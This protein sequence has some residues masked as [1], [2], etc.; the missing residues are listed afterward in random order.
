MKASH[1]RI[2]PNDNLVKLS[3]RSGGRNKLSLA[4]LS[5]E[6]EG[7]QIRL[8]GSNRL[9]ELPLSSVVDSKQSAQ[10]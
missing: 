9:G 7:L 10:G 2:F 5:V 1:E 6:N 3:R 8:G 4:A